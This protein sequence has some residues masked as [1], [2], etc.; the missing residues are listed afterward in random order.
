ME[1]WKITLKLGLWSCLT[2]IKVSGI[3]IWGP[4][5]KDYSMLGL[6]WGPPIGENYH[7]SF[8]AKTICVKR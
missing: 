1:A 7:H 2:G 5:Q 3:S 4:N 6:Y 8:G